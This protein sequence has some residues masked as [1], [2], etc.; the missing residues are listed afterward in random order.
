MY[1]PQLPPHLAHR[2]H[3]PQQELQE[4]EGTPPPDNSTEQFGP[5]LPPHLAAKRKRPQAGPELPPSHPD[6]AQQEEPAKRRRPVAGPSLPHSVASSTNSDD[7]DSFGPSP[8]SRQRRPAAGPSLPPPSSS[9]SSAAPPAPTY[10][11]DDDDDTFGPAPPPAAL[12]E[13]DDLQSRI[14]EIEERARAA[15]EAAE[16]AAKPQKVERG[17]WMLVPPEVQRLGGG[18]PYGLDISFCYCWVGSEQRPCYDWVVGLD[19]M[20]SRQFSKTGRPADIDQSGWTETPQ[21]RAAKGGSSSS[22]KQ[23]PPPTTP[24]PPSST[25]IATQNFIAS[26]NAKHRPASLLDSHVLSYTADPANAQR[27]DASK[28]GFDRD[29]DLASRRVDPKA[30]RNMVEQAKELG[31]R[32]EHGGRTFL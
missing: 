22:S 24:K 30:R 5:A 23:K 8:P 21:E 13:E 14:A 31:G 20:K 27:D 15:K 17:E 7:D 16:E 32:F 1:G 18:C 25:D 19:H 4:P 9:S 6:N 29:R 12:G 11:S 2:K 10:D 28:R 3:S 26:H